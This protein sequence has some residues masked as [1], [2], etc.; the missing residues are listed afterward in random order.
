MKFVTLEEVLSIH[1]AMI[2]IGGGREGIL[3]FTLLHS[4]I[5]RP[6][7]QFGGKFLYSSIFLMAGAMLQSLVKNHPFADGNKRTAF[8]TTLRLLE[9]NGYTFQ[10]SKKT[11]IDFM[12]SVDI[13]KLAFE[14]IALWLKKHIK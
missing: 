12:V 5:E 3:D 8:F 7:A 6:K 9:K 1:E 2:E 4:A 14:E 13:N 10:A 11:I